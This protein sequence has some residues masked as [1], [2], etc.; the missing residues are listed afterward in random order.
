[1]KKTTLPKY[2]KITIY[3]SIDHK[4]IW[5]DFESM[6]DCWNAEMEWL[7]KNWHGRRYLRFMF[8]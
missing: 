2:I 6:D 5:I 7:G 3:Y 4:K 8:N 1:M